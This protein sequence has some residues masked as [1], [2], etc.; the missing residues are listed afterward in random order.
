MKS[1]LAALATALVLPA[2]LVLSGSRSPETCSVTLRLIDSKTGG[3]LNGLL[4]VRDADGNGANVPEL[5]SRGYGLEGKLGVETDAP[6]HRWSALLGKQTV[7]LPRASLVLQAFSGLETEVTTLRVDLTG[8]THADISLPLVRFHNAKAEGFVAGNTHLHLMK[9]DREAADRY[10]SEIPRA[11]G[12][13]VLFLSYLE[14]AGADQEYISNRYTDGDLASLTRRSDVK[15]GNGEEHRHNLDGYGEGYGHVMLLNIEKLIQPV[16]IGPGIMKRGT[17][18]L[19]LQRGIDAARSDGATIVWC[20][21]DLGTEAIPNLFAGR[22]DAQNIFDGSVR[23]SYKD[24]FYRYLNAGLNVPFSTGT[25]WFLYDFSR[26]YVDM[27]GQPT[28]ESWL[29]SLADGKTYITNG[30]LLTFTVDGQ[31]IGT[32]L[33]LDQGGDVRI[34]ARALGRLDFERL[35]LVQNGKVIKSVTTQL[36]GG[37]YQAELRMRLAVSKPCWLAVRTPPPSVADDP[38]LREPTPENELGRELFAHTS[39]IFVDLQGRRHFDESVAREL[40]A[41]AEADQKL[42]A[43]NALFADAQERQR[44]L[45]VYRDGISAIQ[46]HIERRRRTER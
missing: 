20:H 16:S 21:N 13:D 7:T 28:V 19:P 27:Q 22:V 10:L 12:L 43:N 5:L 2:L 1:P 46:R 26:V 33:D 32:T 29:Q 38:E 23:S 11:D 35:E 9:I 39:A 8:K 24:S 37:H 14:R 41:E 45:D 18:G 36:V 40:M 3:E 44:V 30:P 34:V 25:D 31:P 15:F 42:M 4:S 6:I 17:D